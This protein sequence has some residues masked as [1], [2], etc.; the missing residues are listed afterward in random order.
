MAPSRSGQHHD[1]YFASSPAAPSVPAS[2]HLVLPDL[3]CDL[4]VDRGVFS[5]DRID[6]G[7]KFLLLEAPRPEPGA[8]HLLDLGCG[9]GPI[10]V[11]LARRAP[12]ATVWAVDTN[13]RAVAL[14]VRNA[15]RLGLTGVQ[16][17]V[18]TS[19]DPFAAIPAE[20]TF[21]AI[22]SNPPIRIGK[23]ALHALLRSALDR[24]APRGRGYLVVHKHLGA[25][26][27][28]R[29]LTAAGYPTERLG[30]RAGYRLLETAAPERT[31]SP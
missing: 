8:R 7:T 15:H 3:D 12:A 30:S 18:A 28:Q 1:H 27:L 26:S 29:W 16:A 31:D 2:V 21:D 6:P 4:E 23:P 20:I 25:D 24:L 14:C 19:N 22:Y 5:A 10:A 13:E 17:H 11:A 9:Y